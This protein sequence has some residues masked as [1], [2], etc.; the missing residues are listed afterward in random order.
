MCASTLLPLTQGQPILESAPKL[1]AGREST[2]CGCAQACELL[3]CQGAL[4]YTPVTVT[5]VDTKL[6]MA[7]TPLVTAL[8]PWKG[9][10]VLR[11]LAEVCR[12][13]CYRGA[14]HWSVLI[15]EIPSPHA[16]TP[17]DAAVIHFNSAPSNINRVPDGLCDGTPTLLATGNTQKS[18]NPLAQPRISAEQRHQGLGP[19][20][21]CE[22]CCRQRQ[23]QARMS[24]VRPRAR[25]HTAC[26]RLDF[27]QKAGNIVK[28]EQGVPP[29]P[30]FLNV[31]QLQQLGQVLH[32]FDILVGKA[33]LKL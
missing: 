32:D 5:L 17:Q 11:T 13:L 15:P 31:V 27:V 23:C 12:T 25:G 21:M 6:H 16:I 2:H 7:F 20:P 10:T 26:A 28:S 8:A 29:L 4:S 9:L 30:R 22:S 1:S 33:Q 19:F 3:P 24:S 14:A 18:R